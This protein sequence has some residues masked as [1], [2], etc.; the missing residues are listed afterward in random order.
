[1]FLEKYLYCVILFSLKIFIYPL[2]AVHKSGTF[3]AYRGRNCKDFDVIFSLS[4]TLI[5]VPYIFKSSS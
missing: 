3:F 2:C 1:M 5:I 4:E